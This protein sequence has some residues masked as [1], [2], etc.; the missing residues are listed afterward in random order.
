[1]SY[2]V[3][4]S[5]MTKDFVLKEPAKGFV[6][7][8]KS[9]ISP[10]F[11]TFRA[12]DNISFKIERGERLA[13]I[14]P[15]GAGKSTSIKMMS[16]I[17][18]PTSGDISVLGLTPGKDRTQLGYKIGTVF[19]QRSQLWYHLPAGDTFDLL[20]RVYDLNPKAYREKKNELV[21]LFEIKHLLD[22]PVRKLSLGQRM[23]CEV[24][25]SLLHGPEIVFLDE[26]TIGLDVTAKSIIRDLIKERSQRFGTT[27]FLTS[28]DTGDMERVCD[29]VIVINHG[30]VLFDDTIEK[31]RARYIK[32]KR[33]TLMTAEED[34]HFEA[35][36]VNWLEKKPHKFILDVEVDKTP[37]DEVI[38][39]ALKHARIRDLTVEDPQMEDVI[40]FI[41][42]ADKE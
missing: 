37:I 20:A 10:K 8:L 6:G 28:H 33:V 2:A 15:N 29:R 13:F 17:L 5:N 9:L 4:V 40:K 3:A 23:R 19:G 21:K 22:Q 1:M 16:G 14:G 27:V 30:R 11:N 39:T 12:V 25:A 24:V 26:P 18:H 31:L 7:N 32:K 38:A 34:L 36:G 35:R 41:Y 42:R